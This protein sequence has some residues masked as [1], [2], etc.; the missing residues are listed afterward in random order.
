MK[1][2][3][4]AALCKKRK[5]I[6]IYN[7]EESGAQWLGDGMATYLLE[8][9]PKMN[10]EECLR[11]LDV[12]ESKQNDYHCKEMGLPDWL[13]F[14]SDTYKDEE[15]KPLATTIGWLGESYQLFEDGAKIYCI[16]EAYLAP[17]SA[18]ASYT[19]YHRRETSSG[20]FLLGVKI[21]LG[22]QALIAPAITFRNEQHREE[23]KKIA[24]AFLHMARTDSGEQAEKNTEQQLTL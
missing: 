16:S 2:N 17:F 14:S 15:L 23:L 6:V 7:N 11:L 18:D 13:D 19:R 12:P 3:K 20:Q 21:G 22:L 5:T 1:F 8:G 4:V 24:E 9:A 10:P